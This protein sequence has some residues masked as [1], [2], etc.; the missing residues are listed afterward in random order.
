MVDELQHVSYAITHDMRAPLRAMSAF[1]EILID[2]AAGAPPETQEYCRKIQTGA[3]RLDKLIQDALSYTKAVLGELPLEP[4]DLSK[5][6]QG[7]V[8]TYPNLHADKAEIMIEGHLPMVR[9]NESFLTQCFSNLLGNAVKFVAPGTRPSI[10]IWADK[11]AGFARICVR[12]NGVGIPEY[13]QKRLFGMF[14]R[15]DAKH[16]GTGIGLAIVRKVVERMGGKV[17]VDSQVGKGSCFWVELPLAP[18]QVGA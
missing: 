16:E 15:L 6:L 13:A 3:R 2:K 14:Q 12:D 9:G 1:S 8:E 18:K 10:R 5:L 17:G 11:S 7:I 4:V